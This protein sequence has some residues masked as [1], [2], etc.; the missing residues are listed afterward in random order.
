MSADASVVTGGRTL[1]RQ[2]VEQLFNKIEI[3]A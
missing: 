3:T 1:S 2:M